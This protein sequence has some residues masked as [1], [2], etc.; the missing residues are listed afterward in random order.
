[1]QFTVRRREVRSAANLGLSGFQPGA[2]TSRHIVPL[3]LDQ[4][5]HVD[6]QVS[7]E[8]DFTALPFQ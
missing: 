6:I 4:E 3:P 5:S 2:G 1:M 7:S 8:L